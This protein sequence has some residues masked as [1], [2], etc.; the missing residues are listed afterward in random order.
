MHQTMARCVQTHHMRNTAMQARFLAIRPA[1]PEL[2][3][4]LLSLQQSL[5]RALHRQLG[6][7]KADV[8]RI[9]S[10]L[11]HLNPDAVLARGYSVVRDTQGKVIRDSRQLK[12]DDM[13][14]LRFERGGAH[15]RVTEKS[16][17]K[18]D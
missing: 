1:P 8:N 2:K 3:S 14:D 15:A 11:V 13:L 18:Q 5:G 9:A 17:E 7:S 16:T 4:T 6:N 12:L 10:H